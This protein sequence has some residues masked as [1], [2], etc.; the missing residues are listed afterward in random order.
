[1]KDYLVGHYNDSYYK[2][3]NVHDSV[4][5]DKV[6][7]QILYDDNEALSDLLESYMLTTTGSVDYDYRKKSLYLDEIK[8]YADIL[9]YISFIQERFGKLTKKLP[10]GFYYNSKDRI[11]V[12]IDLNSAD[13]TSVVD[14]LPDEVFLL[15]R[16]FKYIQS[17]KKAP[18]Y[19]IKYIE[20]VL[21]S[22]LLEG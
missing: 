15:V 19:L 12:N 14:K 18:K 5:F 2:W 13:N 11:C 7:K 22:E 20:E 10:K 3:I 4:K 16:V 8:D 17:Y 6:H 1:M 9:P 21:A